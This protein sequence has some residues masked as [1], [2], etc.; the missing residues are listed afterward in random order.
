LQNVNNA[1]L[2]DKGSELLIAAVSHYL[3]GSDARSQALQVLAA[4]VE[5]NRREKDWKW[6]MTLFSW[7]ADIL[8]HVF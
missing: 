7:S 8:S 2:N 1:P 6:A 3:H 5:K 4:S